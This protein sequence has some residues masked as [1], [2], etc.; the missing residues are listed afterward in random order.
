QAE[1]RLTDLMWQ[2]VE[3][4]RA[5]QRIVAEVGPDQ[6]IVDHLAY[7]ARLGLETAGVEYADVVLGHPTALPVAG[8]VYGYPPVWP[9][10]FAPTG[11]DLDRLR[12]LCERVSYN[13]TREWNAAAAVLAPD[14]PPL[15]DAFAGHGPVVLYNYP[16]A[17]ADPDRDALLP[18][19]EY[20]GAA[21]RE[22]GADPLVDDWIA[23]AEPF[24]YVSFGSFLSV[25]DDVLAVVAQ[26]IRDA[27]MTAA[28]ATGSTPPEALGPLPEGWLVREYLPQVRLL[29]AA[30]VA[31]SHGGNNSVTEAAAHGV[32]MIVLPFSTDQ[33]A[34][35][36]AI[37][38]TGAGDVLDPNSVSADEI[39]AS[40]RRLASQPRPA[41]LETIAGE[42]RQL[43]GPARAFDALAGSAMS[44]RIASGES[45]AAR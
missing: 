45:D 38:R 35:G 44:A 15:D 9:S 17:L 21:L 19:R 14:A 36:A 1:Q 2:P 5:V 30:A 28:I 3:S 6:I 23:S 33:F 42:E 27:G 11:P 16:R 7:S 32:P 43:A 25:R 22:E 13:F 31:V 10:A 24:V 12:E 18:A 29:S 39:G 40:L 41:V 4:A 26:A 8:E 20:L 34:G 37:E